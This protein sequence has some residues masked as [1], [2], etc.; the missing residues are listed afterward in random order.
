MT[1]K[2][3]PSQRR[4]VEPV[5][6][7][8]KRDLESRADEILKASGL[9]VASQRDER[10]TVVRRSAII[11]KYLEDPVLHAIHGASYSTPPSKKPKLSPE[12]HSERRATVVSVSTSE[13]AII[14]KEW[15]ELVRHSVLYV[16]DEILGDDEICKMIFICALQNP[17][18]S[19][20]DNAFLAGCTG[21]SLEQILAAKQ[22]LRYQIKDKQEISCLLNLVEV[23]KG[24]SR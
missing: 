14:Q 18:V 9:P 10:R 16:F 17:D 24:K 5:A 21:L 12:G 4:S 15:D 3:H 6:R 13:E 22:R 8:P 7:Q 1:A 19:F 23:A 11:H 20:R 2:K